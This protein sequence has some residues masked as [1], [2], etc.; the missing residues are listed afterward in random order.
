MIRKVT[1]NDSEGNQDSNSFNI[2][3]ATDICFILFNKTQKLH[4]ELGTY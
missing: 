3:H 2:L 1:E 4:F